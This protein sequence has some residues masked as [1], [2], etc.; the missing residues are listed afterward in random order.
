MNDSPPDIGVRAQA[1]K[2]IPQEPFPTMA[3]PFWI[4]VF[5]AAGAWLRVRCCELPGLWLDEFQTYWICSGDGFFSVM[6]RCADQMTQFPLYYFLTRICL[7]YLDQ[8]EWA[9]RMVSVIVGSG[10]ILL[11][12]LVA[13]RLFKPNTALLAMAMVA[14]ATPQIDFS[15]WSRPYSLML[16]LGLGSMFCYLEWMRKPELKRLCIYIVVSTLLLYTHLLAASLLAAH[17]LHLLFLT[18]SSRAKLSFLLGQAVI[19]LL[20]IPLVP[21]FLALFESR[22]SFVYGDV[23]LSVVLNHVEYYLESDIL[24]LILPVLFVLG[25]ARLFGRTPD[26]QIRI[27]EEDTEDKPQQESWFPGESSPGEPS[28]E[29][30]APAKDPVKFSGEPMYDLPPWRTEPQS[31]VVAEKKPEKKK[32]ETESMSVSPFLLVCTWIVCILG[33]PL[34]AW[35][36]G[37]GS[38]FS[39]ERYLVLLSVPLYFTAARILML[40]TGGERSL[41]CLVPVVYCLIYLFLARVPETVDEGRDRF[42]FLTLDEVTSG[43][44]TIDEDRFFTTQPVEDWRGVADTLN[45]KA[46]PR[47]SV[48][49]FTGYVETNYEEF[50]T[51]PEFKEYLEGPLS[52]FYLRREL[53][54]HI[55]PVDPFNPEH[56]RIWQETMQNEVGDFWIVGR[57]WPGFAHSVNWIQT[58]VQDEM[59]DLLKKNPR[60][61]PKR[62]LRRLPKTY[63]GN[64]VIWR[65]RNLKKTGN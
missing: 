13:R 10:S 29:T 18:R 55:L 37:C 64:L 21:Q 56:Q 23:S 5:V 58:W 32:K 42:H 54:V 6:E 7:E 20:F 14:V 30:D 1:K 48:Y 59:N 24:L 12:Y 52:D 57:N 34:L 35:Y 65:S 4:I 63:E 49:L 40:C 43:V 38:V 19:A 60:T 61:I 46:N 8:T 27:R 53:D 26:Q 17:L 25:A 15:C 16:F 36:L 28:G 62:S 47:D 39:S 31:E 2:K 44:E 45:K 50:V 22:D 9:M 51:D 33:I 11:A 3:V 41:S